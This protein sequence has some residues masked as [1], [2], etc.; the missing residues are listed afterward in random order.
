MGI[1]ER[2]GAAAIAA[3]LSVGLFGCQQD[4][5][6]RD[7]EE[8]ERPVQ[9]QTLSPTDAGVFELDRN[10]HDDVTAFRL[11][12]LGSNINAIT[13]SI[14]VCRESSEPAVPFTILID[15][16]LMTVTTAGNAGGGGCSFTK[17]SYT[18]TRAV[19]STTA[20]AHSG[21]ADVTRWV[22]EPVPGT[23]WD[24]VY[25]HIFD[26]DPRCAGLGAVECAFIHDPEG[27]TIFTTG[28]S[29]DDLDIPNWRHTTGSVPDADD[30]L[31]AFAAK[32]IQNGEQLLY[33]GADRLAQNGSKDFGFWFLKNPVTRN[34]DGTFSGQ[35]SVGDI[36]ILGTFT[37]GGAVT[38][39]RVFEWVGTGGTA[40]SNGTISPV[41]TPAAFGDC[42][43]SPG[44]A[45]CGTVNNTSILAPWPYKAKDAAVGGFIPSGGFF[46][47]GI[48][49]TALGLEGCFS[50]FVAETRS[51]PSVDATLKDFIIGSFEACGSSLTTTPRQ[52][53]GT[54]MGDADSDGIPDVSI[55]TGAAS[56]ADSANLVVTGTSTWSGTLSFYLC[57]PIAT[58]TCDTGGTLISSH[59]IDQDT[60]TPFLSN[61][62]QV[63][64]A[65]RYCWRGEFDSDTLGVDDSS[66]GGSGECFEVLPVTPTLDTQAVAPSVAF[67]QPVQDTATL[68]GTATQPGAPVINGPSG[69]PAGGTIT[70]TLVKADCTTLATGTG[71][72]PQTVPVNGN[73]T[74]GPVSFTPDSPGTYHWKAV[75]APAPGDPNNLG[76]THNDT[77]NDLDETVV[78]SQVPTTLTTRQFVFPQDKAQITT[79]AGGNLSGSVTFKLFN[80]L[81]NCQANSSNMVGVGGLLYLETDS[82]SGAAP[83]FATTNN[84]TAR[85]ITNTTVYWRVTYT[86]TNPAQLGSVSACEESTMVSFSG[87]NDLIPIP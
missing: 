79:T 86:S 56:A 54:A 78:V 67:G 18:V 14:V 27:A 82:I 80:T 2:V 36:L 61:A 83:Q 35:H 87:N 66:D 5:R 23:D 85:V 55:G 21:G 49:L 15:A 4:G 64:S 50:T 60:V 24:Q 59:A 72:N 38:T 20:T 77:C 43:T 84:T 1:K 41:S 32:F 19:N 22:T 17:R 68:S 57:G 40:T 75:Y 42:V 74:Y 3:L 39:I 8:R 62:A 65:G 81:A 31:D 37:G 58:G 33:F 46:E 26:T 76:T 44:T 34:P 29:K 9:A 45:G 71:T 6:A 69:P 52:A 12:R 13:T 73:G 28:G 63:T 10:A 48:N 53:D 7:Q 51:S 16:E 25:A 70:F 11:G 47:G 30:I